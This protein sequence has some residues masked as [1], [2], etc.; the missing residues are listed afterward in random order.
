VSPCW[1]VG[2]AHTQGKGKPAQYHVGLELDPAQG[3]VSP[4]VK[5]PPMGARVWLTPRAAPPK[6]EETIFSSTIYLMSNASQ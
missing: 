6:L 1:G 4:N 5:C 2:L 3:Q